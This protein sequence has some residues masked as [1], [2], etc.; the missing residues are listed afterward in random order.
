MCGISGIIDKSNQKIDNLKLQ[1]MNDLISHRGPNDEGFFYQSNFAFAHRRL[2]ILDLSTDGH[3][4]MSYLNEKYTLTYN[5]EIYNYLELKEELLAEGYFFNSDTDTE[6]ILAAYDKWGQECIQHFNGMWAFALYDKDNE[7]IFCSR[8]RFGIK[9]FYYAELNSQFLFGSEIKQL[10]S[11]QDKHVVEK[12]ILIDYL[13]YGLLEHTN[14]TFFKDILKLP[15]SHNLIYDLQT[16]TYEIKKYYS[17]EINADLQKLNEHQSVEKY[18][19]YFRNAVQIRLRS[20]VKV[21]TCLSGGLDSSSIAAIA[22]SLYE[23]DGKDKFC[24]IHAKST[25]LQTDESYYAKLVSKHCS[26]DL[27]VIEPSFKEFKESIEHVVYIQEEPFDSPSIF[28]QYFVMKQAK[29]IGCIVM[30]DGQGG[31]ETLFGYESYYPTYFAS[32]LKNWDI[33]TFV[34]ELINVK[35]FKIPKWKIFL[36]S[37][38]LLFRR[39]TDGLV[40]YIKTRKVALK[41]QHDQ[42]NIKYKREFV[43]FKEF[44][45]R[46]IMSGN[47]PALLRYEDKNSMCHSIETRLPFI[48]YKCV[49]FA[50]SLADNIKYKDGFLKYI[51]RKS[52]DKLL[53]SKITWRQNKFGFE[54]PTSSWLN[55]HREIMAKSIYESKVLKTICRLDKIDL[56]DNAIFWRLYNI[57]IWEKKFNVEVN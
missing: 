16:H 40:R 49:N 47:M 21:G 50:I 30:L 41:V 46:E 52:V 3:Q 13:V 17:I 33:K 10:L 44:Q 9:P 15:Q 36:K 55:Q 23:P 25:E 43:S 53:P 56:K 6:V 48:D 8:D 35:N 24:A 11:C 34:N 38:L 12:N 29:K 27:H 14:Q 26:L 31:D 18:A 19:E 7:V 32:L 1:N 37:F 28:M 22:S 5:G 45:I 42:K 51:L 4:P 20:D 54:S 2:S 57:A 39:Q